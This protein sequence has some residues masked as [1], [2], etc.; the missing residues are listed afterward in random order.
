[1]GGWFKGESKAIA[2]ELE[3]NYFIGARPTCEETWQRKAPFRKP[4]GRVISC[5]GRVRELLRIIHFR[6]RLDL[7]ELGQRTQAGSS[8][9][10]GTAAAGNN[11]QGRGGNDEG[12]KNTDHGY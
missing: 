10:A 6:S 3:S 4:E 12:G 9:F 2:A 5:R 11:K 7:L 1:M 8:D